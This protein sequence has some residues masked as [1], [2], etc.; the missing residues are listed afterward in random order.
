MRRSLVVIP[1]AT[2]LFFALLAASCGGD[3]DSEGT[4]TGST[5]TAASKTGTPPPTGTG[6]AGGT[7]SA[8]LL[9]QLRARVSQQSQGTF[10][11]SYAVRTNVEGQSVTGTFELAQKPPKSYFRITLEGLP[12]ADE[13]GGIFAGLVAINDGTNTYLCFKADSQG[14]C[15][16]GES[17]SSSVD[18]SEFQNLTNFE[19]LLGGSANTQIEPI[20][21]R[22][23][24][25]I[26]SDCWRATSPEF[27]GT[28][29]IGRDVP[30]LTYV[31]GTHQGQQTTV[32][33]QGYDNKVA[34]TLFEPPYPVQEFSG[35]FGT[36]IPPRGN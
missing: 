27:K 2:T 36:P 18:I 25:G 6:Q 20:E 7:D 24:A 9:E 17:G 12:T 26:A 33:L 35:F 15:L 4:A 23:V 31:E 8:N 28:F 10:R 5:A 11:L 3:E 14:M 13:L 29:C 30:L 21:G 22:R 16:K 1:L 32:E 19:S 34:D